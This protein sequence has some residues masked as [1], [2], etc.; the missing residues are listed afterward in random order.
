LRKASGDRKPRLAAANNEHGGVAVGV[1][2]GCLAQVE[3][4]GSPKIA[5]ISIALRPR[6]SE[7]LLV[8]LYFIKRGEQRPR[9]EC[10]AVIGI[11]RE[12]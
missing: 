7:P 5:R 8:S 2:G 1:F 3:P 11:R 9:L 12:P 4:I 6:S 10:T